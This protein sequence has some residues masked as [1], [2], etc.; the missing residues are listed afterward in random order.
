MII[1]LLELSKDDLNKAIDEYLK[2]AK[3]TY[4]TVYCKGYIDDKLVFVGK[5][6]DGNIT[7]G[8][9]FDELFFVQKNDLCKFINGTLTV[10]DIER[11]KI[12]FISNEEYD[13]LSKE[14]DSVLIQAESI[15]NRMVKS[16]KENKYNIVNIPLKRI[17]C[18]NRNQC[19]KI[20]SIYASLNYDTNTKLKKLYENAEYLY[21]SKMKEF[22][23]EIENRKKLLGKYFFT[24][25]SLFR[26]DGIDP[27]NGTIYGTVII[28]YYSGDI[29]M[30]ENINISY[31]FS[32]DIIEC[33]NRLFSEFKTLFE[34]LNNIV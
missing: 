22:N 29:N 10:P 20:D 8:S 11:M 5:T 17:T 6:L 19:F 25:N 18:P 30:K 16:F 14:Y 9:R 7:K 15:H 33:D 26:V 34:N 4:E 13:R 21:E 28:Y 1:N 31:L 24:E 32:C 3:H 12:S 23:D 27:K 2:P